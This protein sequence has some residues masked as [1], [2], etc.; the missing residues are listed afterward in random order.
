MGTALWKVT[1][2]LF[3]MPPRPGPQVTAL[4]VLPIPNKAKAQ[5]APN[6]RDFFIMIPP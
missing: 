5:S 2:V 4:E 6:R 3:D 1:A